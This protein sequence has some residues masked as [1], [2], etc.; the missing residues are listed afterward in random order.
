MELPLIKILGYEH[1]EDAGGGGGSRQG[2]THTQCPPLYTGRVEPRARIGPN[3]HTCN[4]SPPLIKLVG[5]EHREDA[6]GGG[7]S[8]QCQTHTH[9]H[10]HTVSPC[11]TQDGWS[12]G[13]GSVAILTHERVARPLSKLKGYEHREDAVGGGGAGNGKHTHTH[14]HTVST[15]IH[16]VD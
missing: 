11:D 7:G 10:T 13:Q 1:R 8:R 15:V 9:T 14:T 4:R 5:Y 16:R 3:L 2:Q 6:V 12:L